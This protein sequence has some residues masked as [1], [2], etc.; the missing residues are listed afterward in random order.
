MVKRLMV[1]FVLASSFALA[2]FMPAPVAQAE[3]GDTCAE[4]RVLLIPA[5]YNGLTAANGDDCNIQSPD[6]VGGLDKFIWII[7]MNV[8]EM[9]L[10]VAGYVAAGFIMFGGYKY[11][12]SAGSPD[13][14]VAARKT[15]MNACIGLIISIAAAA[16]VRTLSSA[17]GLGG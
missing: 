13:G 7:A 15:I 14:M 4:T 6:D 8:V 11:M 16:I 12:Y 3:D 1:A 9:L 10:I 17:L 2:L 5:W